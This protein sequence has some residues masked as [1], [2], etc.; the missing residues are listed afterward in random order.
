MRLA[1]RLRLKP[2][3]AEAHKNLG[4]LWLLQGDFARGWPEYEWRWRTKEFAPYVLPLPRWDGSPLQGKTILLSAEQGLGDTI[5]FIRYAPLVKQRG[6]TVLLQCPPA[7]RGLLEGVAGVDRVLAQGEALPPCDVR[8]ALLSLPGLLETRLDTIPAPV[9]YLEAKPDLVEHWRKELEPLGGFK[10]GIVWQGNPGFRGDRQRSIPL[11]HYE[12]LARV[13][14]VR[15]VSLQKGPAA[16]QLR[17]ARAA[18]PILELGQR[19]ETFSD[20]AAVLK[21][22]DLL[23]S[24]CTSVPHLAGAGRAG[25]A[26]PAVRRRLALAARARGQPVVSASSPVPPEP[27]RRLGRGLPAH[28]GRIA[29]PDRQSNRKVK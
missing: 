14:G 4:I 13:E 19:L 18:F 2:A 12:A 10:V 7:L 29:H 24:S 22:V 21:N 23:I 8:A 27:A 28:R 26:G 20:T 11:R 25:V 16:E 9:P 1:A 17:P 15:L 5:Q 3:Y 6:G